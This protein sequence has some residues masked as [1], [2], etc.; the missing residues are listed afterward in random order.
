[1]ETFPFAAKRF[2]VGLFPGYFNWYTGSL[3]WKRFTTPF[4]EE[5]FHVGLFLAKRFHVACFKATWKRF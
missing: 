5:R 3:T 2:H 4:M 1:V